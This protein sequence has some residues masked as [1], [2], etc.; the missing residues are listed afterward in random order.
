MVDTQDFSAHHRPQAQPLRIIPH[1]VEGDAGAHHIQIHLR[2]AGQGAAV[3]AV[4][5]ARRCGPLAASASSTWVKTP[6]CS[7]VYAS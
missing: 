7:L 2:I 5:D 3:G 1:A 4:A 6:N